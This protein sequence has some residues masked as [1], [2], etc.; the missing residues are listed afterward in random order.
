MQF[1]IIPVK[2]MSLQ[3]AVIPLKKG[4]HFLV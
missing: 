1:I 2:M 4:I 3:N